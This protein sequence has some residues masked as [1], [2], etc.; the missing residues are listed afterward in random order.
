[1]K[2]NI[3]E[4]NEDMQGNGE[5]EASL[6]QNCQAKPTSP[7]VVERE[8]SKEDLAKLYSKLAEATAEI[9]NLEKNGYNKYH[10]YEYAKADDI[11]LRVSRILAEKYNIQILTSPSRRKVRRFSTDKGTYTEIFL[12]KRFSFNCGD[13]GAHI[14]L[15]YWGY[16][17]GKSGK[18][19]YKAYTGCLKYF[20]K[21]NFLIDT[22]DPD[23]EMDEISRSGGKKK[24]NRKVQSKNAGK[25]NTD[26]KSDNT[27]RNDDRKEKKGKDNLSER[28]RKVKSIIGDSEELRQEMMSYLS[29][30]KDENNLDNISIDSLTEEQFQEM[31][32]VLKDLQ[33][34]VEKSA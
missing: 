32:D 4:K 3:T 2:E 1:M 30:V 31:I 25:S 7:A 26:N 10:N 12:E 13:T 15:D 21:D 8:G 9:I 19:L 24:N 16:D 33:K 22:G 5:I 14:S 34:I 18:F 6:T 23:P 11:Y 20:L 29:Y 27:Q 17:M 28:E